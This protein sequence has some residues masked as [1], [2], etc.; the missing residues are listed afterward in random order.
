MPR[1]LGCGMQRAVES[2]DAVAKE[3][4]GIVWCARLEVDLLLEEYEARLVRAAQ[5]AQHSDILKAIKDCRDQLDETS[6]EM[7]AL[8]EMNDLDPDSVPTMTIKGVRQI[9]EA[10]VST[11][12]HM[13][14]RY[15]EVIQRPYDIVLS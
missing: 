10:A 1:L 2:I 15:V 12:L 7:W 13:Q 4:E 14:E 9:L 6:S 5:R 8:P 11:T 3:A